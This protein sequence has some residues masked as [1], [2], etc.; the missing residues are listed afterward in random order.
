MPYVSLDIKII[1]GFKAKEDEHNCEIATNQSIELKSFS[2][3]FKNCQ[4]DNGWTLDGAD[5]ARNE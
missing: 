3:N 5:R 2:S 4:S 1:R